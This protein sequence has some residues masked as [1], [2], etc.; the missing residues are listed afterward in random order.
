VIGHFHPA[1]SWYDGAGSR[2]K[3]PGLV[4]GR[5]KII[6]PAFSP[7]A[8]GTPWNSSLAEADQLWVIAPQRIFAVTPEL[9]R[10]GK[11]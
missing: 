9:L 11:G 5:R 2:I 10:R 8:A 6:L 7:W 4:H 3:L 1:F